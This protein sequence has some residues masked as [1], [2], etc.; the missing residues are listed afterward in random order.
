MKAEAW[1]GTHLS[2]QS[3]P[4]AKTYLIDIPKDNSIWDTETACPGGSRKSMLV[5]NQQSPLLTRDWELNE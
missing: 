4:S 3:M 5:D 1:D 2:S